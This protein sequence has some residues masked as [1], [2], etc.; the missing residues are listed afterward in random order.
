MSSR[1]EE[2]WITAGLEGLA[3]VNRMIVNHNIEQPGVLAELEKDSNVLYPAFDIC[4]SDGEA[5]LKLLGASWTLSAC[6]PVDFEIF[7]PSKD[8]HLTYAE[9][10][11]GRISKDWPEF[12][13]SS[14]F[15]T[16][17]NVGVGFPAALS[18][19]LKATL[20][21]IMYMFYQKPDKN[22]KT[23]ALSRINPGRLIHSPRLGT[24]SFYASKYAPS[25]LATTSVSSAT[26]TSST[27][28]NGGGHLE[29]ESFYLN[30]P[31]S[32]NNGTSGRH[33]VNGGIPSAR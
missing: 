11:I 5:V 3:P 31:H 26:Y 24:M 7:V 15:P 27:F 1:A 8:D 4:G 21:L 14:S 13:K 22:P 28:T 23:V 16:F 33:H 32:S 29:D 19:S 9:G 6:Q 25:I 10:V 2:R 18:T 17:F 20:F 12:G 30:I